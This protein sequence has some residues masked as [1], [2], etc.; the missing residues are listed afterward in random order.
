MTAA[1]APAPSA[2]LRLYGTEVP[3]EAP[4]LLVAGPLSA[5]LEDGNLRYI[6]FQGREMIRAVSY[7]C[8]LY[9]SPS[10]RDRG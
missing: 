6:R 1:H 10:P 9:T 7:I 2:A 3:V 5:E 4:R 8:L